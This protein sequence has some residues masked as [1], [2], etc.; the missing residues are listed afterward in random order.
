MQAVNE[1][2]PNGRSSRLSARSLHN[3][4][5]NCYFP[6]WKDQICWTLCKSRRK[7]K[8]RKIW[9][10]ANFVKFYSFKGIFVFVLILSNFAAANMK[11]CRARYGLDQQNLWCKPCRWDF[12]S[13]WWELHGWFPNNTSG[14][15]VYCISFWWT[16]TERV[17]DVLI[18]ASSNVLII[19]RP[20]QCCTREGICGD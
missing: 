15:S 3:Y 10:R 17:G 2:F 13:H 6:G 5:A 19:D 7:N 9:N 18:T 11:K 14:P 1:I 16:R 4:H 20:T 8:Q 12:D